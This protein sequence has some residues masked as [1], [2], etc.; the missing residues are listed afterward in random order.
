MLFRSG[1][2]IVPG[3][4]M[5]RNPRVERRL[6][7]GLL[8]ADAVIA[9][10]SYMRDLILDIGVSESS[11]FTIHNGVDIEKFSNC[12]V[13]FPHPRTYILGVGSLIQRKGFD[14]L[15]DAMAKRKTI[16]HD[17]LIAGEGR[18]QENLLSLRNRLGL[19]EKVRFLGSVRGQEKVSLYASAAFFICSSRREPFAN[20]ILEALAAGLPVIASDVDG[21]P[22]II[23]DHENGLLFNS[24]N[25][26]DL[27]RKI[28]LLSSDYDLHARLKSGAAKSAK[29]FDWHQIPDSYIELYRK[30]LKKNAKLLN[31]QPET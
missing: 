28:D 17:L 6:R 26:D 20:V 18:E 16:G 7:K 1:S 19:E 8:A 25:S 4:R 22:E 27:A 12:S 2:D 14:I 13:R 30:V 5:R 3:M 11:V 21:N 23:K 24:E 10:G 29:N 15:L 9:Q 31:K